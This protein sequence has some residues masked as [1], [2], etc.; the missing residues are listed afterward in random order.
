MS[1]FSL[2]LW[3]LFGWDLYNSYTC[4]H[5]QYESTNLSAVLCL[6]TLFLWSYPP[7][8]LLLHFFVWLLCRSLNLTWRVTWMPHLRMNMGHLFSAHWQHAP[9]IQNP[10]IGKGSWTYNTTGIWDAIHIRELLRDRESRFFY[11]VTTLL[12]CPHTRES[13]I[14]ETTEETQSEFEGERKKK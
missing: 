7:P 3:I 2:P 10:N 9:S 13:P 1:T 4:Y 12:D 5:S 11:D 6:A 8:K 14:P